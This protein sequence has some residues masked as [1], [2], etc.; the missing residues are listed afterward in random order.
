MTTTGRLFTVRQVCEADADAVLAMHDRCG[1][2]SRLHRWMGNS[3]TMPSHYLAHA[4]SGADDHHAVVA[5][6]ATRQVIALGSAVKLSGATYELGLLVEDEFQGVGVGTAM[7]DRLVAALPLG[8]TLIAEALFDNRRV[9]KRLSRYGPLHLSH[10]LGDATAVVTVTS[11]QFAGDF[12][13]DP[14]SLQCGGVGIGNLD[15]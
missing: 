11:A 2:D 5:E 10:S 3:A 15:Q 14:A 7:C 6:L 12:L 13:G 9:L 1:P 4:L 8:A